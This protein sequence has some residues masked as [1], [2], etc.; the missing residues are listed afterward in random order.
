MPGA[1]QQQNQQRSGRRPR[2]KSQYGQQL[3][4]KQNLKGLYGIREEQ[5]RRYYKQARRSPAE[6]GPM[7]ISLLE[8]RLDNAVYRA[9]F[10]G[11]RKQARQMATHGLFTINGKSTDV[12]SYRLRK[13]DMVQIK[14]TKR[15]AE[16]FSNFDKRMQNVQTP[17]W[18]VI[19]A[20]D[21]GFR[22]SGEPTVAD[23]NTGLQI[24][25]IVEFLAR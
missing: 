7:M 12:P 5:L 21:F 8:R 3:E 13:N 10:A 19:E 24:Q 6:T 22:V 11:T 18:I 20:K 25:S 15:G 14:E 16:Y 2:N 4:E 1:P 17:D 9:G 23:A